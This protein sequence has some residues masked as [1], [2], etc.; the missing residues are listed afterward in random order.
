MKTII[1]LNNS[2]VPLV[3]IDKRLNKL[4]ETIL[5]P[6]KVENAKKIIAKFGLPK[7]KTNII[8]IINDL[9]L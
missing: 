9:H 5:F 1:E 2:K 8:L 7:M 6:E 4:S 3:I